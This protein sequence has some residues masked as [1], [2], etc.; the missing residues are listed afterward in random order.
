MLAMHSSVKTL[1]RR[2]YA[3]PVLTVELSAATFPTTAYTMQKKS[4]KLIATL[5][6]RLPIYQPNDA[7]QPAPGFGRSAPTAYWAIDA[8]NSRTRLNA[9]LTHLISE[10]AAR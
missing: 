2:G 4:A 1:T 9:L 10:T 7:V 3:A 6:S 5:I 8:R